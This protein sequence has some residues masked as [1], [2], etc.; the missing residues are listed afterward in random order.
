MAQPSPAM[1]QRPLCFD[2]LPMERVWGGRQL[3][4]VPGIELPEGGPIG[5]TWEL[6]DREEHNSTVRCGPFAGQTL[7]SLLEEHPDEILGDTPRR[8][9]GRF[10]LLV[11]LLDARKR[12]SLQVHPDDA[13]AERLGASDRG[14][15][16]AWYILDAAPGACV[17]LGLEDQVDEATLRRAIDGDE[18]ELERHLQSLPVQ[19]GDILQVPSGT[20]HALGGGIVLLEVQQNSDLTYR[21]HDWGRVGLD[22][23]P[24]HLHLEEAL[25]SIEFG[26]SAPK[27][28]P[29]GFGTL[30]EGGTG[31]AISRGEGF[32]LRVRRLEGEDPARVHRPGRPTLVCVVEGR[33]TLAFDES[34]LELAP[35]ETWLVPASCATL[36]LQ[37]SGLHWLEAWPTT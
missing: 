15:S 37:G 9:D 23:K 1:L 2:R 5:E 27:P 35:G 30:G 16:E 19:R 14:K 29:A 28:E 17:F 36:E 11:K 4:V 26:R 12:L 8:P 24:R 3:A 20:V 6:V 34:H 10:P 21:L 25:Q 13:T 32:E 31:S 7:E 33:G 18:G 22:G